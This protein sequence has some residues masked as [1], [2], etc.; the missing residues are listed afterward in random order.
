MGLVKGGVTI[1]ELLIGKK[2]P[3]LINMILRKTQT[4]N[5]ICH[6]LKFGISLEIVGYLV[7]KTMRA[8]TQKKIEKILI[9]V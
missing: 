3:N 9:G 6:L 8:T 1:P 4:Y 5:Y 7:H 2:K